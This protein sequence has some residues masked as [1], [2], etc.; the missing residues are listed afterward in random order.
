MKLA[1]GDYM[2]ITTWWKGMT[3]LI[4]E[5]VNLVDNSNMLHMFTNNSYANLR[6]TNK[7]VLIPIYVTQVI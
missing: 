5:D 3:F 6:T 1:L 4:G 2:K 7:H